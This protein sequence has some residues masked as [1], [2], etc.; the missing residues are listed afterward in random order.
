VNYYDSVLG[1][2]KK[3]A[4][5]RGLVFEP[6]PKAG[7]EWLLEVG[8]NPG[9]RTFFSMEGTG[10]GVVGMV[11]VPDI[12]REH[13]NRAWNRIEPPQR[14]KLQQLEWNGYEGKRVAF[15]LLQ[16]WEDERASVLI[17]LGDLFK[18]KVFKGKGNFTVKKEGKRFSLITPRWDSPMELKTGTETVLS[19]L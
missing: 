19:L 13:S 16:V 11:V 14:Y 4:E 10:S 8:V 12:D 9:K 1:Q 3:L 5:I 6:S 2:L 7:F 18:L 15:T 17:P